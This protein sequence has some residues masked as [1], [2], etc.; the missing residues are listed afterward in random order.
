VFSLHIPA[1][2]FPSTWPPGQDHPTAFREGKTWY[3]KSRAPHVLKPP[4]KPKVIP[5]VVILPG[6]VCMWASCS[7][8]FP[9]GGYTFPCHAMPSHPQ[10]PS[11]GHTGGL[12]GTLSVGLDGAALQVLSIALPSSRPTQPLLPLPSALRFVVLSSSPPQPQPLS[13]SH[14]GEEKPN[15]IS[16]EGL[17]ALLQSNLITRG[18]K[19][20]PHA[21]IFYLTLRCLILPSQ[22]FLNIFQ[23]SF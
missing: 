19:R 10:C 21:E 16:E 11:L 12:L 8:G 18:N 9:G 4:G 5:R 6:A 20:I 22:Q 15:N 7:H 13:L 3:H 1:L 23:E 14:K 2:S 17:K